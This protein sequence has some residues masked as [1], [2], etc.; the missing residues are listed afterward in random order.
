MVMRKLTILVSFLIC[1]SMYGQ[2]PN[3]A[4]ITS[5][6]GAIIWQQTFEGVLADY[7]P[8]TLMLA[9][10]KYH[11]AGYLIHKGDNRIHRLWG[12]WN[13]K[14]HVHLQERDEFD[15]L[16]GFLKG[17]ITGDQV[18]LEWMSADQN[19][20]FNI[21]AYPANLVKIRNFKPVAEWIEVDAEED[22]VISVQKMDFGIVSGL[23]KRNGLYTRFE[24]YCLDGSCSIW[25]T[26]FQ[27]P[28]GAPT[29]VQMR[30]RDA[31]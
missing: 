6:L 12:D 13:K 20:M 29:R 4:W 18:H 23:A 1:G 10:D 24:G 7:H 30:Q 2:A 11:V 3:D 31:N 5:Q 27:N 16:T 26:V 19:R 9:S 22:F 8:V 21:V 14:D 28:T 15:R 17:T 25:N